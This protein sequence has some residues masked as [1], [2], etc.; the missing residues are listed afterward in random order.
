MPQSSTTDRIA[1]TITA[2]CRATGLGRTTIYAA[3]KA[4][5]LSAR[6]AGRRTLILAR[7]LEDFLN[8]LPPAR[9]PSTSKKCG[10]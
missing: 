2:T 8:K 1:Y 7:D 3:L 6:K 5:T 10:S 4:G 9:G